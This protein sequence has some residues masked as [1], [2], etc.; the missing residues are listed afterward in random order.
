MQARCDLHQRSL[1]NCIKKLLSWAPRAWAC[2]S[3]GAWK[4]M[5]VYTSSLITWWTDDDDD[6]LIR[7]GRTG[8]FWL[9]DRPWLVVSVV[10]LAAQGVVLLCVH[11]SA[12]LIW[13]SAVVCAL[14][15]GMDHLKK[16]SV[17]YRASDDRINGSFFF[18]GKKNLC[19]QYH[20]ASLILSCMAV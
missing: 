11:V 13:C 8:G 1:I 9:N 18:Q 6:K 3:R 7:A 12:S 10:L 17:W 15:N 19:V 4:G 16:I 14:S 2:G 20:H 5:N